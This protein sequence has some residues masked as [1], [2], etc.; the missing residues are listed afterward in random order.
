MAVIGN[1]PLH[2][3]GVLDQLITR[4]NFFTCLESLSRAR[5]HVRARARA[6]PLKGVNRM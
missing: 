3:R 1:E 5:A 6:R 4:L 2:A